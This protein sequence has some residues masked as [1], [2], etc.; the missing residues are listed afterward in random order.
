MKEDEE[1]QKKR[2][3]VCSLVVYSEY[4]FLLRLLIVGLRMDISAFG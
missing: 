4:K 2:R 1:K 3:N